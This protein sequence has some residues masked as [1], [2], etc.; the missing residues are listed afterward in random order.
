MR[1]RRCSS[2]RAIRPSLQGPRTQGAGQEQLIERRHAAA[3]QILVP[4]KCRSVGARCERD[5]FEQGIAARTA[6]EGVITERD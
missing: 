3:R 1:T 4:R 5:L 2:S 6:N